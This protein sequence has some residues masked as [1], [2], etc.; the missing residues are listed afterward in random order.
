MKIETYNCTLVRVNNEETPFKVY[1]ADDHEA[2]HAAYDKCRN[3]QDMSYRVEISKGD[4][5][6]SDIEVRVHGEP[7]I[8]E[9]EQK[10][11]R[12]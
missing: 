11:V 10:E 12:A 1:A 5:R 6:L 7:V 9:T 3:I 4:K 2:R 8:Y